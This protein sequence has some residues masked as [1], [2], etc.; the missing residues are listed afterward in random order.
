[1]QRTCIKYALPKLQHAKYA[2]HMQK[3]CRNM[4]KKCRKHARNKQNMYKST[5]FANICTPGPGPLCL[6]MAR[7]A[8]FA[9]T[10][11]RSWRPTVFSYVS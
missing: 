3:I 6:L 7:T 11:P 10:H 4:E 5:Y 1:M 2:E 8:R 9:V